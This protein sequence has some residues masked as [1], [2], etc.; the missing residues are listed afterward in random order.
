MRCL[1]QKRG[2]LNSR[3]VLILSGLNS[4]NSLKCYTMNKEIKKVCHNRKKIMFIKYYIA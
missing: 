4:R 3:L 1:G 2:G